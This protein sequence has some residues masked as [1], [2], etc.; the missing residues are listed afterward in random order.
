MVTPE[1]AR[2]KLARVSRHLNAPNPRLPPLVLLCDDERLPDPLAAARALPA[3]SR[4]IVRARTARHRARLAEAMLRLARTRKLVV[5]NAGDPALAGHGGA[6]GVHF[7]EARIGEIAHWRARKPRWLFTCAA[8]SPGAL[9]RAM[10][11][12]ADAAFVSP[13]FPS[14]SHPGRPGLG[15]L[16]LRHQALRTPLPLYALGGIAAGNAGR[17]A[18]ARLCG[19]AAIGALAP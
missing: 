17:L 9:L 14:A 15:P 12:G 2:A 5:L 3:G 6:A 18:G 8:H 10:M 16:R 4:V 13:V 11:A 1:L 19:L 7:A